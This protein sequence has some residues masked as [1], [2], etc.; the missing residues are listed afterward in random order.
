M[1]LWPL[2]P[3]PP[4]SWHKQRAASPVH[5]FGERRGGGIKWANN[6][7]PSLSLSLLRKLEQGEENCWRSLVSS[8]SSSVTGKGSA[9]TEAARPKNRRREREREAYPKGEKEERGE[10]VAVARARAMSPKTTM[11]CH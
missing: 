10:K 9:R 6:K 7:S 3:S 8:L 11:Y 5:S 4:Q 2:P 1:G